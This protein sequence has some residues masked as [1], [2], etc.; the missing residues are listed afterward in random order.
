MQLGVLRLESG[1]QKILD[2]IKKRI[3]TDKSR[4]A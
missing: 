3:T 1:S 4:E 2:T